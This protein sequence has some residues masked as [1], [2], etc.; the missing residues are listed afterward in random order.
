MLP[1]ESKDLLAAQSHYRAGRSGSVY[2]P[3]GEVDMAVQSVLSGV[4]RIVAVLA[5][6]PVFLI[7][8]QSQARE[9]A[10][11]RDTLVPVELSTVGIHPL[12]GTPVVLLREPATGDVLPLSVGLVEARSILRAQKGL[13]EQRPQPHD[14]I[15]AILS[16]TG[17]RL[18]RVI[19]DEL[20]GNTYMSALELRVPGQKDPLL[21][22]SRPSDGLALAARTPGVTIVVAS[23]ILT[24]ASGRDREAS[25]EQI[26]TAIGITVVNASRE[27]REALNLP[28]AEGVLVSG[29]IGRAAILGLKE[30][31]LIVRVNGGA[32]ASPKDFLDKVRDTPSG[33]PVKIRYWQDEQEAAIELETGGSDEAEEARI[34]L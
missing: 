29:V 31:S 27:L 33:E 34:L 30:G 17:A 12:A 2:T 19:V 25:Q 11:E 1:K 8:A 16:A 10:V 32:P 18:V 14:L 28:A 13:E 26:V 24:R 21:V 22:D 7:G 15:G 20:R 9:L 4:Q 3:T 5:L 6:V 23:E